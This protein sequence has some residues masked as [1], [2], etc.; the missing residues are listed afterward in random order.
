[1]FKNEMDLERVILVEEPVFTGRMEMEMLEVVDRPHSRSISESACGG[2]LD[3]VTEVLKFCLQYQGDVEL[4]QLCRIH[5]RIDHNG[6]LSLVSGACSVIWVK[7]VPHEGPRS[8][9]VGEFG[10]AGKRID[11]WLQTRLQR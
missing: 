11:D 3:R 4:P 8:T 10:F 6:G 5:G 9:I 7:G 2:D 1:M